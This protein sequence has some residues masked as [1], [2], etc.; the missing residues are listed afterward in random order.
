MCI[1]NGAASLAGRGSEK[2][3]KIKEL[4]TLNELKTKKEK[5]TEF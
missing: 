5:V 2:N 4:K 3:I 1:C